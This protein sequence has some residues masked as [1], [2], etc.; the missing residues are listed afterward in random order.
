ME[1][2][3][4]K[5]L[6]EELEAAAVANDVLRAGIVVG[7]EDRTEMGYRTRSRNAARSPTTSRG[8]CAARNLRVISRSSSSP[9]ANSSRL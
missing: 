8:I 6:V 7:F 5:D 3:T 4:T 9:S 2:R 1:R